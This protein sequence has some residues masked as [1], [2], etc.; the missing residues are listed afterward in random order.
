MTVD[1]VPGYEG[2]T[3]AAEI[4]DASDSLQD[5]CAKCGRKLSDGLL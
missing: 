2:V 5:L 4:L 1:L 3:I